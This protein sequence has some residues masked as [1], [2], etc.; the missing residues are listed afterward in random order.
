MHPME[1]LQG[2]C[3]HGPKNCHELPICQRRGNVNAKKTNLLTQNH[4]PTPSK[5]A[6][7]VQAALAGPENVRSLFPCHYPNIYIYIYIYIYIMHLLIKG[8]AHGGGSSTVACQQL[9]RGTQGPFYQVGFQQNAKTYKQVV[10][11]LGSSGP[12]A[13]LQPPRRGLNQRRP[14]RG[15]GTCPGVNS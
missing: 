6:C 7:K 1:I 5:T 10:V 9:A 8:A 11:D 14:G 4:S 2:N 3:E 12:G 15:S 13:E